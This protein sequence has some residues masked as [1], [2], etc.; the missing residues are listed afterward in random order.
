[1]SSV[2]RWFWL[3]T[4]Q[5]R[6]RGLPQW[7]QPQYCKW[8]VHTWTCLSETSAEHCELKHRQMPISHRRHGREKTVSCLV[9]VGGVN[10]IGD[11]SRQFCPVSTQFPICNCSVSNILRT[12]ENCL[13]LSLIRF[14]PPTRTRQV[15]AVWNIGISETGQ[16]IEQKVTNQT[17]NK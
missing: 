12:T 11:K 8:R 1:M 14:T 7:C 13:D 5:H 10:T 17:T 9:G 3:Q 6:T 16:G 15:S 2:Y 4:S